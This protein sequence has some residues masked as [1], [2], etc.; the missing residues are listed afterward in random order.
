[1]L[2]EHPRTMQRVIITKLDSKF[3]FTGTLIFYYG[4]LEQSQYSITFA[5]IYASSMSKICSGTDI[6]NSGKF[7]ML[8]KTIYYKSRPS[9]TFTYRKTQELFQCT[10]LYLKGSTID[11]H[12]IYL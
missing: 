4:Y 5:T 6:F 3:Q 2:A 9:S 10:L 7:I 8:G 12:L 1:M 11:Y